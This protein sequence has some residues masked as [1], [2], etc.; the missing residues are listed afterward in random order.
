MLKWFKK[1]LFNNT[2]HIVSTV[3]LQS[4]ESCKYN[5]KKLNSCI[6]GDVYAKRGKSALCYNGELWSKK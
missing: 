4:C 1:H 6:V 2:K 5:N 3:I